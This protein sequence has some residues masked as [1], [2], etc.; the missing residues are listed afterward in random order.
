MKVKA[1]INVN[2]NGNWKKPGDI[3]EINAQD[4]G[5]LKY[6]DIIEMPNHDH[7]FEHGTQ[8]EF[9]NEPTQDITESFSGPR[10]RGRP[11]RADVD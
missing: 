4:H 10:R 5:I 11:K 3:F 1:K 7:V 9:V 2:Y 8:N 6:V